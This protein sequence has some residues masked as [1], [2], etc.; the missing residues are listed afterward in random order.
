MIGK[1][2]QDTDQNE[3]STPFQKP[4]KTTKI[5]PIVVIDDNFDWKI[6]NEKMKELNIN[7]FALKDEKVCFR[8]TAKSIATYR[9]IQNL[10]QTEWKIG[11]HSHKLQ[12]EKKLKVIIRGL[13][14]DT[15]ESLISESLTLQ[16]INFDSIVQLTKRTNGQKV[17]LP[18]FLII[19][20]KKEGN[21]I[22][23]ITYIDHFSVKV[24]PYRGKRIGPTQCHRCQNFYHSQYS[25]RHDPRCVKCAGPHMT[26]DCTKST[27]EPPK[28]CNCGGEHPA[29]FRGCPVFVKLMERSKNQKQNKPKERTFVNA[30]YADA[31]KSTPNNYNDKLEEIVKTLSTEFKS[32]RNEL[33]EMRKM[34]INF[35]IPNSGHHM[36]NNSV[37]SNNQYGSKQ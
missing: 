28:C 9:I 29:S 26:R 4:N 13:P 1:Y 14:N 30:S 11:F 12:E 33:S 19:I 25:C 36:M 7:D 32:F 10:F 37:K 20:P 16:D 24:E 35:L 17:P 15:P 2:P 18:L 23:N 22:Y 5:P 3:D 8:I 31:L 34:Q 21:S 6:F 27:D